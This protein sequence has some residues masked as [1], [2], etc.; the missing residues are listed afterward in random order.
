MHGNGFPLRGERARRDA[1]GCAGS[2]VALLPAPIRKVKSPDSRR[3]TR[4]ALAVGCRHGAGRR[5]G[6]RFTQG[7]LHAA[8]RLRLVLSGRLSLC[9]WSSV[10]PSC[11][12][13]AGGGRGFVLPY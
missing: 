5:R 7:A 13:R 2:D 10:R 4:G 12:L 3:C 11:P 1:G 8:F 9:R 6:P